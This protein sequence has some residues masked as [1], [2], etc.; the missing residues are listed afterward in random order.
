MYHSWRPASHLMWL[1]QAPQLIDSPETFRLAELLPDDWQA[2]LG[3]WVAHPDARPRC[4]IAPPNPRL[5]YYFEELYECVL[6]HLLGRELLARNVQVREAGGRTL[7][8]MDFVLRDPATGVV[9]HH[10]IA[11]KFYLGYP[12]GDGETL[13]YGPNSRDRLDRKAQRMLEH[14]SRLT[15]QP[16]ARKALADLGITSPVIPRIFMPGYLFYPPDGPVTLPDFVPADHPR[17]RW[18]Y[19]NRVAGQGVNAWVPLRKPHWLGPWSQPDRP[20]PE[21]AV[22]ALDAV[23]KHASPRLFAVLSKSPVTGHWTEVERVF[24]V[25][26]SWPGQ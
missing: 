4:L 20:D 11:V 15:R 10:E 17:G 14:Q 13:W 21:Q 9:E 23:A 16:E 2:R 8:E 18:Q 1:C 25:P 5:G 6:T 12:Q 19:H 24:V 7:G 3:H 22:A 26:E